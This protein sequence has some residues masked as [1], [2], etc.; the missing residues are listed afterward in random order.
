[1]SERV[2][3]QVVEA[4]ETLRQL[5]EEPQQRHLLRTSAPLREFQ[6][7]PADYEIL[8]L[9]FNDH[10]RIFFLLHVVACLTLSLEIQGS[11]ALRD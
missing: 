7:S 3:V 8:R 11:G 6:T 9:S 10:V 2:K 1:M 5:C 4:S